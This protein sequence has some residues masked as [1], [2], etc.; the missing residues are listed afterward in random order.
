MTVAV[1][2]GQV[3]RAIPCGMC[4]ACEHNTMTFWAGT[5]GGRALH[6]CIRCGHVAV[7][8]YPGIAREDVRSYCTICQRPIPYRGRGRPRKVCKACERVRR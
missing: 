6:R 1:R 5:T 8:D 4:P 2:R 3:E 7:G